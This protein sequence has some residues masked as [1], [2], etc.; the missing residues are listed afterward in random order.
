MSYK[1]FKRKSK[2][3]SKKKALVNVN[4]E[5]MTTEL[6]IVSKLFLYD[7]TSWCSMPELDIMLVSSRNKEVLYL[8]VDEVTIFGW[9][10]D[11]KSWV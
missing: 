11:D 5:A 4:D 10:Q 7:V 8:S 2:F 9:S 3:I 1:I 6:E